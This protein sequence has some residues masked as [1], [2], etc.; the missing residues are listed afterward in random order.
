MVPNAATLNVVQIVDFLIKKM[1]DTEGPLC[2]KLRNT[3]ANF[4]ADGASVE[5]PFL[6]DVKSLNDK[7]IKA[8]ALIGMS[9]EFQ[10][11]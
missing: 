1:L 3:V 11:R 5:E 6:Y 4:I 2:V 10:V 7:I 8:V 9:P